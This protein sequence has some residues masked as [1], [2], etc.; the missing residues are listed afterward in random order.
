M[1]NKQRGLLLLCAAAVLAAG[2]I[3]AGCQNASGGGSGEPPGPVELMAREEVTGAANLDEA[4]DNLLN[5]QFANMK[6]YRI[7]VAAF[8]GNT[9]TAHKRVFEIPAS[10]EGVQQIGVTLYNSAGEGGGVKRSPSRSRAQP[11]QTKTKAPCSP[12]ER[13]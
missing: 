9:L 11:M 13:A 8:S 5:R 4:L 3:L 1:K 7:D 10:A 12:S 2:A 6:N